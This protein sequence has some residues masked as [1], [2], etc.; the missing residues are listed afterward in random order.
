SK[1]SCELFIESFQ[2]RFDLDFTILRY[3]SLYGPRSD[4]SNW[5]HSIID[6]ALKHKKII[7][8]GDG[9]E[10]R[11]YIHVIDAARLT[12]RMIGDEFKNQYMIITGQQTMRIRDV[13]VMIKEMLGNN[14]E[15]KF[16]DEENEEHYAVTP[17]NFKPRFAKKI[18]NNTYVDFGQGILELINQQFDRSQEKSS[19][20]IE[21][22]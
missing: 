20:S 12:A 7:R 9:E 1:Q 8:K 15:L 11:E 5:I 10:I 19:S 18:T 4:E 21:R 14:I 6:Q 3:G 22:I 17:Y 2:K 16:I 13:L